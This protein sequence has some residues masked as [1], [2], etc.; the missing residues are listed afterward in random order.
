MWSPAASILRTA[1]LPDL[2]DHLKARLFAAFD[3]TVLWNK[4]GQQATINVE[5][6]DATLQA[7]PAILNPSQDGYHDTDNDTP[8]TPALVG[9]LN[10]PTRAGQLRN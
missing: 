7:L 1:A 3:L 9:P 5:I 2:P 8:A 10:E 4:P 6:T